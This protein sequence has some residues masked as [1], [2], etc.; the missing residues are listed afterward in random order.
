[1]TPPRTSTSA[2]P[3][4]CTHWPTAPSAICRNAIAV[5]LWV[6]AWGRTRT[7]AARANS[8]IFAMLR[9]SASRSII[10]A[11][12]STSA[13]G[14]PISAGGGFIR[15][16]SVLWTQPYSMADRLV[17]RVAATPARGQFYASAWPQP[18]R[19]FWIDARRS[20]WLTVAGESDELVRSFRPHRDRHRR[21]RRHR[22]RHGAR[23]RGGRRHR[24][25]RRAQCQK[26]RNGR[27]AYRAG[28]RA[29]RIHR[30]R[31]DQR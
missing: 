29:S 24:G 8:A 28:R 26:G 16:R 10:S 20:V 6:L 4:F 7:A 3:T 22:P 9:S 12:V 17:H 13:T 11:G 23:S 14:T 25:A 18:P 1:L 27:A 31:R 30:G 2:S 5:D 15:L 19:R 21:Q